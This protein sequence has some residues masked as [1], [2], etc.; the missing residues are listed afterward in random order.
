MQSC[1]VPK[2]SGFGAVVSLK[3]QKQGIERARHRKVKEQS[4]MEMGKNPCLVDGSLV[5]HAIWLMAKGSLLLKG[6]V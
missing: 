6:V 1:D 5:V 4:K 2:S 3:V